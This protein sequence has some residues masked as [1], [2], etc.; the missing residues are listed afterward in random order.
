MDFSHRLKFVPP[1]MYYWAKAFAA[2]SQTGQE[3]YSTTPPPASAMERTHPPHTSSSC[4]F[5][6][7]GL[8]K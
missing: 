3:A 5:K 7:S 8:S 1:L 6:L 4:V 2:S